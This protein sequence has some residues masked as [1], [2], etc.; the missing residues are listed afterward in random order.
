MDDIFGLVET[1]LKGSSPTQRERFRYI[2]GLAHSQPTSP[3]PIDAAFG[4]LSN[5]PGASR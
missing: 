3:S 2:L 1:P 4:T 5:A